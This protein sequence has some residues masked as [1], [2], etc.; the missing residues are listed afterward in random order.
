MRR[1]RIRA[2]RRH[3]TCRAS[4]L[5]RRMKGQP[6]CVERQAKPRRATKIRRR[7]F[8]DDRRGRKRR[9]IPKRVKR[10]ESVS[11][12]MSKVPARRLFAPSRNGT[13]SDEAICAGLR[14]EDVLVYVEGRKD[15]QIAH[16]KRRVPLG[17]KT[18][19][20]DKARQE[21]KQDGKESSRNTT[22]VAQPTT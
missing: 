6:P 20:V 21:Y 5:R 11:R 14:S 1:V 16:I 19:H 2:V 15:A 3:L 22:A 12:T 4:F 10:D 18:P 8:G 17:E 7:R 9:E 13:F